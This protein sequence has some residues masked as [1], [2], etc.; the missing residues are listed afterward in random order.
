MNDIWYYEY[1]V[2]IWDDVED[3]E[4]IRCGVV[5]AESM[6][7]ATKEICNYYPEEIME[8]QMLKA[9]VDGKVFEFN[10]ATEDTDFDFRFIKK[11]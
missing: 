2:K 10:Y 1:I 6:I 8:I 5:P 3:K 9:I 7:E 11:E 4:E